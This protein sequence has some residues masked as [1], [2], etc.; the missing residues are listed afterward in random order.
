MKK[1]KFSIPCIKSKTFIN[2]TKNM[3]LISCLFLLNVFAAEAQQNIGIN[4]L[5]NASAALDVATP[6][7]GAKKGMLIPRMSTIDRNSIASPAVGLMVYDI[8]L[9]AF[10]YYNGTVWAGVGGG[11]TSGVVLELV[12]KKIA[13]TQTLANAN[14]SNTGDVVVFDNVTTAPTVGS[15][16]IAT[17]A[18]TAGT[19]G[20]YLIQV[21]FSAVQ[22]ATPTNTTAAWS[23]AEVNGISLSTTNV[24]AP[25]IF[26]GGGASNLPPGYKG[27]WSATFM[28]YL[29]AGDFVK[30]RGLNQ[31][32]TVSNTLDN[33]GGCQFMVVKM[34]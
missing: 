11:S 19:A 15:Y 3:L 21:K 6:A 16:S 1:F 14:A 9:N 24:Y 4:T 33:N 26:N 10:Y 28:L 5:P 22:N 25:Y 18:Y 12:A 2:M 34:N 32:S 29:N 8:T 7:T 20:L 23:Y 31:N 27:L 13:A 30:I 17:N